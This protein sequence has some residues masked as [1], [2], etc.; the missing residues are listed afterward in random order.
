MQDIVMITPA[1]MDAL[2]SRVGALVRTR[3]RADLCGLGFWIVAD[4]GDVAVM[5][6]DW[7]PRALG[8]PQPR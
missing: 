2:P 1:N 3:H 6:R 7:P 4:D 8:W 5:R